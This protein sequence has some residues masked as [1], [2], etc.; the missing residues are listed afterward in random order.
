MTPEPALMKC[1]QVARAVMSW[2]ADDQPGDSDRM[3]QQRPVLIDR[4]R[5]RRYGL[6]DPHGRKQ[7]V[8]SR[9][10]AGDA[11]AASLMWRRTTQPPQRFHRG[12]PDAALGLDV[13]RVQQRAGGIHP[14]E[15]RIEP[16]P[17]PTFLASR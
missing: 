17:S 16:S 11:M 14:G 15:G 12:E 13:S 6:S 3:I 5:G 10:G 9:C 4:P 2:E 1:R 7:N 8:L